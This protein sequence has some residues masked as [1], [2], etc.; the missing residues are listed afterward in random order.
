MATIPKPAMRVA[1]IAYDYRQQ[2]KGDVVIDM[3]CYRRHGHNEGDDP[4]YTQ[5]ILYRKIKE[6]PSVAVHVWRA[7]GARRS[8]HAPKTWRRCARPA[9]DRSDAALRRKCRS[10]AEPYELQELSAVVR[11]ARAAC[12]HTAV[13]RATAGARGRRHHAFPGDF[14]PASQA[15]T[16]SSRS[17]AKPSRK[18]ARSIGPSPKR[19]PSARW[20]CEGT[21]RAPERTGFRPRH[22]QPAPLAFYDSENG[23]RYI[24]LQHIAPD[25]ARF[26]VF[27]SSLSEYAVLGFEFGYSVADPLTL[28]HL[29]SAVRRFRQRRADHD[30]SVHR[31]ARNRNGASPAAW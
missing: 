6:H 3:I 29:G 18:T 1:Q 8:D 23:E 12:P 2:F 16:D 7:P 4:S 20:C 17:A 22:F 27:D 28:V 19:W 10:D 21:P 31:H 25:Q 5:P 24:P 11:G 30:R 9:A 14:P 26:D 15:A 13:N